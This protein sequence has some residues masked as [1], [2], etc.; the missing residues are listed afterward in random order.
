MLFLFSKIKSKKEI[1]PIE[2][3]EDIVF[4]FRQPRSR[5]NRN[6]EGVDVMEKDEKHS[7]MK[8]KKTQKDS[9]E[10][11]MS[12]FSQSLDDISLN[13]T[14]ECNHYML[15]LLNKINK[16]YSKKCHPKLLEALFKSLCRESQLCSIFSLIVIRINVFV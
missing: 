2:L 5:I 3:D 16:I 12:L 15:V 13:T 6:D 4:A 14:K 7:E 11:K 9:D 8:D 10:Y 1:K